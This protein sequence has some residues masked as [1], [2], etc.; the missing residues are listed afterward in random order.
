M[1]LSSRLGVSMPP[2]VAA[3]LQPS[4]S[5]ALLTAIQEQL[6]LKLTPSRGPVGVVV[7]DSAALPDPE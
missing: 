3:V 4:D 1:R 6:G 5:K 7:I 2:Q